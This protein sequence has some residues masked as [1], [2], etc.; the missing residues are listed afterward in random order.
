MVTLQI[1]K[2]TYP[3]HLRSLPLWQNNP[4]FFNYCLYNMGFVCLFICCCFF[5]FFFSVLSAPVCGNLCASLAP[6]Y[7]TSGVLSLG[8]RK[9]T[10]Y[11]LPSVHHSGLSISKLLSFPGSG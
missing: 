9:V 10:L 5:W 6:D 2:C 7:N 1:P 8:E 3:D 11:L 4:S